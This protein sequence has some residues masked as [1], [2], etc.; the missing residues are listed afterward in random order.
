MDRYD[1]PPLN[2]PH[3]RQTTICA[4]CAPIADAAY[5]EWKTRQPGAGRIASSAA[6]TRPRLTPKRLEGFSTVIGLAAAGISVNHEQY[7]PEHPVHTALK[8]LRELREWY[9][10]QRPHVASS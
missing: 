2:C 1:P 6:M 8:Y 9:V 3:G 5:A 4:I 7:G 10:N